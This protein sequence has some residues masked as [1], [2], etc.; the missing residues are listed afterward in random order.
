MLSK[1]AGA[2][3]PL[4]SQHEVKHNVVSWEIRTDVSYQAFLAV[5]K[6]GFKYSGQRRIENTKF[7]HA[8]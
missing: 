4:L 5:M 3:S 6:V 7:A 8:K 1:A 2:Q